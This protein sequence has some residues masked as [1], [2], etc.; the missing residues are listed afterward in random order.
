MRSPRPLPALVETTLF[1]AL[2]LLAV[3]VP[4]TPLAP[5][6]GLVVPDVLYC[7]VIGWMVRR[8]ATAPLWAVVALGLL[9][10][11]M[12]AWPLG[13]GALGLVLVSEWFRRWGRLFHSSPFPLEWLA[14]TVGFAALLAGCRL[15]LA[16]VFAGGPG[17]RPLA[18]FLLATALAYPL[19]VLGLTWCLGLRAPRS[20]AFGQPMGRLK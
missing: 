6:G 12:L 1:L 15:A 4:L 19:V 9:G 11:V 8:P 17:T 3:L 2:G 18:A 7:L 14:A 20:R 10:D 16:L 5:A 13:L